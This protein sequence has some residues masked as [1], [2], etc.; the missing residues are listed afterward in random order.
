MRGLLRARAFLKDTDIYPLLLLY[1]VSESWPIYRAMACVPLDGARMSDPPTPQDRGVC[2]ARLWWPCMC[3]PRGRAVVACGVG[4]LC[5][6]WWGRVCRIHL[7]GARHVKLRL[8]VWMLSAMAGR[9]A[10][11]ANP[12]CSTIVLKRTACALNPLSA[13][14][15][16]L[17]VDAPLTV[18][19]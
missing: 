9:S 6:A 19:E 4:R 1:N 15:D 12:T 3:T 16:L 17:G 2:T 13:R 8:T 7:L 10:P 11:I 5:S 18:G 14:F